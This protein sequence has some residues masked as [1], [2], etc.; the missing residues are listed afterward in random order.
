MNVAFRNET[1]WTGAATQVLD[2]GK[3]NSVDPAS[4]LCQGS[5]RLDILFRVIC[6]VG[7]NPGVESPL[8]PIAADNHYSM[9]PSLYEFFIKNNPP[10]LVHELTVAVGHKLCTRFLPPCCLLGTE[11]L[12][13]TGKLLYPVSLVDR[14]Q[15]LQ[16]ENIPS[17]NKL[18]GCTDD[19]RVY[20]VDILIHFQSTYKGDAIWHRQMT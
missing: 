6:R 20:P 17:Q 8:N 9:L 16:M 13:A 5:Q 11:I 12:E 4:L 2:T 1:A 15:A 14:V 7:E 3:E 19:T 18:H 10:L